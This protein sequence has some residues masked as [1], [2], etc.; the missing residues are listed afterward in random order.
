MNNEEIN[1]MVNDTEDNKKEE[2]YKV[3]GNAHSDFLDPEFQI[4]HLDVIAHWL[5]YGVPNVED[6]RKLD[7]NTWKA[8][9]ETYPR[10]TDFIDRTGT[11]KGI[12]GFYNGK[13]YITLPPESTSQ[14]QEPYIWYDDFEEAL[15]KAKEKKL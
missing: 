6:V 8:L 9:L 3:F 4:K 5:V 15:G 11:T 10:I 2:Y 7:P 14:S 12:H 1:K 13:F